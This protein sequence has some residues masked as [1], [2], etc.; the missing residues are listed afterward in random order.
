MDNEEARYPPAHELL[1]KYGASYKLTLAG[2]NCTVL[3]AD[4][5]SFSALSR[6]DRDRQISRPETLEILQ[7]TLGPLTQQ[8]YLE[9][10][11]DGFLIVVQPQVPTAEVMKLV[12]TEL[13]VKLQVHNRA[14][15]EARIPL[16][17]IV[18]ESAY[19][20]AARQGLGFTG[21][22]ELTRIE[23]NKRSGSS[24]WMGLFPEPGS[25]A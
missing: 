2:G 20:N 18:S 25:V 7:T 22:S 17:I 14:H 21:A 23:V 3:L 11:G 13:P 1:A 19:Q 6:R 24:A 15:L 12:L 16:G 8:Y 10:R 4:V 5:V 9:D